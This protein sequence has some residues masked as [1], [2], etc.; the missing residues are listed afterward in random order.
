MDKCSDFGFALLLY[1]IRMPNLVSPFRIE[2]ICLQEFGFFIRRH[3]RYL[4]TC[5][6]IYFYSLFSWQRT[7]LL[8]A[9][10]CLFQHVD[11]VLDG[12]R[13]VGMPAL[14]YVDHLLCEI[15]TGHYRC[16]SPIS[17]LACYVFSEA[18]ARLTEDRNIRAALLQLIETMR[19]DRQRLDARLTLSEAALRAHH[20]QTFIHSMDVSLMMVD[21]SLRATDVPE[22]VEAL[23][24]ASPM[25]D[26]SAD[27]RCGLIN[28]PQEVIAQAQAEGA[29]SLD[30]TALI[31]TPAVRAWLRR[32]F[33]RGQENL[34]ALPKR[35]RKLWRKRG[36]L[37]I[38]A[39]FIEIRR[40]ALVYARRHR[41][42][43]E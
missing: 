34:C 2:Q 8:R 20:H 9:G 29:R 24:W 22:M 33:Q 30:Y 6:A 41:E 5:L 27:L 3:R 19:F 10:H 21:S 37:E 43:L 16:T 11:D 18:D 14:A 17:A 4:V 28:V 35:L 36:A 31:V 7:R 13:V 38:F 42:I 40:Y 15:E 25:R 1:N 23:A 12:D 32:E 39:F 26:L